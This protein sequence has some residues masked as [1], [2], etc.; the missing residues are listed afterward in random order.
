MIYFYRGLLRLFAIARVL[1]RMTKHDGL[2]IQYHTILSSRRRRLER[3]VIKL[4]IS[5][6]VFSKSSSRKDAKAQRKQF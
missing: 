1:F 5:C 2:D 6:Y 4:R 3:N